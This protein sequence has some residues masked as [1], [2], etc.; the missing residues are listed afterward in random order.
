MA[1]RP[2]RC[3]RRLGQ[4]GKI[5][6]RAAALFRSL[7]TQRHDV[8]TQPRSSDQSGSNPGRPATGN[9]KQR[10]A[11]YLLPSAKKTG[12]ERTQPDKTFQPHALA[13][14]SKTPSLPEVAS[15]RIRSL[16]ILPFRF[17]PNNMAVTVLPPPH[18]PIRWGGDAEPIFNSLPATH[19]C[20]VRIS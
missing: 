15:G 16:N 4:L 17:Y 18:L 13:N 7:N 14:G 3:C 12:M 1:T 8:R 6:S 9:G 20:R 19:S 5:A 10:P 11:L 2:A